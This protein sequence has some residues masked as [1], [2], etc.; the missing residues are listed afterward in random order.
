AWACTPCERDAQATSTHG[1]CPSPCAGIHD[2]AL[3]TG[4]QAVSFHCSNQ[5]VQPSPLIA[6][7]GPTYPAV[8]A[9]H[10][11]DYP[12]PRSTFSAS[13]FPCDQP[14]SGE[15]ISHRY[16]THAPPA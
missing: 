13:F 9:P 3:Q 10:A 4:G 1:C 12:R 7:G 14:F 11:T 6:Q 2:P 16:F 5:T 8:P 15:F